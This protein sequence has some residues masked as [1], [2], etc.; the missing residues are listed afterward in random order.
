MSRGVLTQ[1]E[2]RVWEHALA[3]PRPLS[4]RRWAASDPPATWEYLVARAVF[5]F[6]IPSRW[7]RREGD[8][9]LRLD[10][11]AVRA[12][13]RVRCVWPG[14]WARREADDCEYCPRHRRIIDAR[15]ARARKERHP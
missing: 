10:R 2:R 5:R 3:L 9:V 6:A 4:R 13:L 15:I 8:R 12:F 14:C 11:E 7:D 1:Y